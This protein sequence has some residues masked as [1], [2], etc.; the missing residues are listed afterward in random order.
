MNNK[1]LL[2]A[3]F[4]SLNC[5]NSF[6]KDRPKWIDNDSLIDSTYH[7]VVCS[8]S[9]LDPEDARVTAEGICLASAAKLGGVQ[10]KI[11]IKTIQSLTGADS[12][13]IAEVQPLT[14]KVR[15]SFTDR[16]LETIG[17]GY[18]VWL[19]CQVKK[20]E[21]E[22]MANQIPQ[23]TAEEGQNKTIEQEPTALPKYQR[24]I[25]S[26]TMLPK[27][28]KVIIGG[29]RGERVIDPTSNSIQLEIKEGDAWIEI[30]KHGYTASRF[31][32]GK[33]KHGQTL[34]FTANLSPEF[35]TLEEP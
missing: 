8:Q 16:Y 30:K 29:S 1:I 26:L 33:W 28:D 27:G 5:T 3:F 10:V 34:A 7:Y 20:S 13:E 19:R 21:V 17:Q 12:S 22:L 25:V 6:G 32:L 11:K 35:S 18:R 4:I 24:G 31:E 2:F 23:D 14:R 15:C 9:A